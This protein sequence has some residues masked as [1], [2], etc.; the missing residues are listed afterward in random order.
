MRR[1][2]KGAAIW[3][4]A[5]LYMALGLVAITLVLSAAVPLIN[6]IRDKNTFIQTKELFFQMDENVKKVASEGPGSRRVLS[7]LEVSKGNLTI[8]TTNEKILWSLTTNNKMMEPDIVFREGPVNMELKQSIIEDEYV[9]N[10]ELNYTGFTDLEFS[11]NIQYGNPFI[12]TYSMT[13]EHGGFNDEDL[14]IV[15]INMI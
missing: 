14:P 9:I 15:S 8:D 5:V 3:V 12:G 10:L 2:K 4:S 6:K 1:N 11:E 7:P 13:I